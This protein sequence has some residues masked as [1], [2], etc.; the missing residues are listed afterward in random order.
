MNALRPAFL[1][2]VALLTARLSCLALLLLGVVAAAQ[3]AVA[4]TFSF[5][6]ARRV[7]G[8]SG[9]SQSLPA[10]AQLTTGELVAVWLDNRRG[11]DDIFLATAPSAAANF[12]APERISSFEFADA[13]PPVLAATSDGTA[14]AVFGYGGNLYSVLIASSPHTS[15]APRRVNPEAISYGFGADSLHPAPAVAASDAGAVFVAWLGRDAVTAEDRLAIS[16]SDDGG[17]T[18]RLVAVVA[19]DSACD[20]R[21]AISGDDLFLAFTD[22]ES[23]WVETFDT[24]V[25]ASLEPL[26]TAR[27]GSATPLCPDLAVDTR[28]RP[29]AVA[30]GSSPGSL[31]VLELSP[32]SITIAV[33]ATI[34]IAPEPR[35]VRLVGARDQHLVLITES[36]AGIHTR[37][38]SLPE[39]AFGPPVAVRAAGVQSCGGTPAA[40]ALTGGAI[41]VAWTG[42]V[43]PDTADTNVYASVLDGTSELSATRQVDGSEPLTVVATEPV[44]AF[45]DRDLLWAFWIARHPEG[46]RIMA[47]S[48]TDSGLSFSAARQVSDPRAP[49]PRGFLRAAAAGTGG[50]LLLAWQ[51]FRRGRSTPRIFFTHSSDGGASFAA[52]AAVDDLPSLGVWQS[53]PALALDRRGTVHVAWHDRRLGEPQVYYAT[54]T[55]G[56]AGFSAPYPVSPPYMR[57]ARQGYPEL[58]SGVDGT[59][60][61]AW[62]EDVG[63][64]A[65]LFV[66]ARGEGD[67]YFSHAVRVNPEYGKAAIGW[68]DTWAVDKGYAQALPGGGVR[69]I[70]L[71]RDSRD[72]YAAVVRRAAELEVSAPVGPQVSRPQG[73]GPLL[74]SAGDTE[75]AL[76]GQQRLSG[77]LQNA[78]YWSRDGGRSGAMQA[79]DRFAPFVSTPFIAVRHGVVHLAYEAH[80][81]ICL[82]R[83]VP[84]GNSGKRP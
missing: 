62:Y 15:S 67:S 81:K 2:R 37:Y 14:F 57:N 60:Y 70:W 80:G 54:M 9:S 84:R 12:A 82:L 49:G 25:A 5:Y 1:H 3:S 79:I 73:Y 52:D 39:L 42:V 36:G 51:D 77:L 23:A 17:D 16:R 19:A 47:A 31:D 32:G 74:A 27:L 34:P 24:A 75:L 43:P 22:G 21:L 41:A 28:G 45:A 10:L 53:A 11:T 20:P 44:L 46:D 13:Y 58:A 4:D 83:A 72:S 71:D 59:I 6:P 78:L 40:A 56:Q 65:N 38:A 33:R 64:A 26:A 63:T 68:G 8:A 66:V 76:A 48:S 61:L 29:Y 18:Y 30:A 35:A 7:D 69:V 50:T 55:P